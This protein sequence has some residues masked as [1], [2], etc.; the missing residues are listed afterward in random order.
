MQAS[1]HGGLFQSEPGPSQDDNS[2][3]I[4]QQTRQIINLAAGT[5]DTDAVYVAQLNP[6][7]THFYS[8]N[9]DETTAGNYYND[10]AT[11]RYALAAGVSAIASGQNATAVR[12][13]DPGIGRLFV[14]FRPRSDCFQDGQH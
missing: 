4:P 2:N 1:P 9:F 10:G 7:Q 12:Y 11:G 5:V 8:V 3:R 6:A 13:D 14:C